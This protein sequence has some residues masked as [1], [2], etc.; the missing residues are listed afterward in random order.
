MSKI[1]DK[2]A[3]LR[4]FFEEPNRWFHVREMARM[5][6]LTPTTVSKYLNALYRKG[7][8]IKKPERKHLL[9]K[10]D[11]ENSSYKDAKIYYNIKLLRECGLIGYLD[12]KLH[13]PEAVI[14][15]GSYAKGENNK[16]SDIDLFIISNIKKELSSLNLS[17]FEKKLK[18][19]IQLF[20][21]NKSDFIK[22]QKENKNLVN[23]I[24]NGFVIKGYIEVFT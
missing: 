1:I 16:N 19:K 23:S 2:E 21:K 3:A 12:N 10:A 13:Y 7:V 17:E 20:I 4:H 5:L 24:L 22:L 8:I 18:T 11:T 9:F 14:L 6:K 15:F